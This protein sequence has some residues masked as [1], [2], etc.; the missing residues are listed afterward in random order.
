[1][2]LAVPGRILEIR[3]TDPLLRTG[4]V[5]FCGIVKEVHLACTPEARINDYV[6]VH[7]G[8]ALTV[9]DEAEAAGLL[10]TLE[11]LGENE[12]EIADSTEDSVTPAGGEPSAEEARGMLPPGALRRGP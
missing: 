3:G 6:L 9:I 7:V 5:S 1:M 8:F 4:R 12:V 10:E 2:C 11:S